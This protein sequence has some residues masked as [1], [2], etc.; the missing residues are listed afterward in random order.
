M[1]KKLNEIFDEMSPSELEAFGDALSAPELEEKELAAIKDAANFVPVFM[2]ANM[3]LGVALLAELAKKTAEACR[4]QVKV[5]PSIYPQGGEKVLIYHTTGRVVPVGKLPLDAGCIVVN[6][7]TLAAI[8]GKDMFLI[9]EV[10]Q[11]PE[12]AVSTK[13]DMS[14]SSTVTTVRA[15]LR[16]ILRAVEVHT[17][18]A[19]LTR[20]AVD[21]Y[22]IDKRG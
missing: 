5:L 21:F 8:G 20:A 2:S 19:T 18:C 22:I 15:A 6:C 10:K 14:S 11:C 9:L 4:V 12:V 1:K 17:T 7:T 3:S 16:Y 13:D